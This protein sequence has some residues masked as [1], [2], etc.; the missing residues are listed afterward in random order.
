[1]TVLR[2]GEKIDTV[3]TKGSTERS[4][5]RLMV[6]RDVLLRVEK[7]EHE[8]GD[9]L[10]EVEDVSA[11]DD[12]G[13][14]AVRDVSLSVRAGE[15]VGPRRRRRQ[16]PERADRGDHRPA[17]ARRRAR[18][19]CAGATSPGSGTRDDAGGRHRPHRRG[20]PPPRPRARVHAGGEPDAARVP[21]GPASRSWAGCR[22][23]RW[24]PAPRGCCKDYD[25]RG[26]DTETR[27][28]SL[29]GGNQ[30]KVRDRARAVGRPAGADRRAADPRARRRRDRVRAPPAGRGARQGPRDPA[31][32]AGAGGDPLAVGPRAG[33]LRGPDRGRDVARVLRG[34]LR[35]GDDR[36]RARAEV[37][38]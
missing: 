36:R 28:A 5:A 19:W 15:I 11:V 8:A 1:M 34:G 17:Q 21:A 31:R 24:P 7:P 26:G 22:R 23:A 29:S 20:P 14:P 32:L 2:R 27:A 35:R 18:S 3:E 37:A 38:A 13:L 6:G 9:T 33:D 30:Q 10:L 4:L 16:R 25:V 12:R